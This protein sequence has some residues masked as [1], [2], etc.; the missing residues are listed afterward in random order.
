MRYVTSNGGI[1]FALACA[2]LHESRPTRP[3]KHAGDLSGCYIACP[4]NCKSKL[5]KGHI[6]R[7]MHRLKFPSR[8]A[9]S[10]KN[11]YAA[12]QCLGWWA[13]PCGSAR[14]FARSCW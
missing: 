3:G 6:R 4:S 8:I 10:H 2:A 1:S 11:C 14:Y 5:T 13:L 9:A 7:E 12:W